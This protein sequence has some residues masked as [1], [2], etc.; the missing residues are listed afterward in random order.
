MQVYQGGGSEAPCPDQPTEGDRNRFPRG[1]EEEEGFC[2]HHP[3]VKG[4]REEK[5]KHNGGQMVYI[6][7]CKVTV[8]L[9]DEDG[10]GLTDEEIQA[11]ANTFMFAGETL[12][13]FDSLL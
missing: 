4:K 2:G 3:A 6:A 7:C 5:N 8:L 13:T 12:E 1:A 10:Q 11:E 9:Q